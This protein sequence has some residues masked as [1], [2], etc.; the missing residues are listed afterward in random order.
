L[1]DDG[2]LKDVALVATSATGKVPELPPAKRGPIKPK[3]GPF[4]T[5]KVDNGFAGVATLRAL[6]EP[7]VRSGRAG[8]ETVDRDVSA[9]LKELSALVGG[10]ASQPASAELAEALSRGKVDVGI[11]DYANGAGK[12]LPDP[13][14]DAVR[15][16]ALS[17]RGELES[18]LDKATQVAEANK[19]K[20]VWLPGGRKRADARA[21]VLLQHEIEK[22]ALRYVVEPVRR[23]LTTYE[24]ARKALS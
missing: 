17:R 10:S 21:E 4:H 24:R 18:A 8:A 5:E 19:P 12:G 3:P 15:S 9:V 1:L 7:M 6:L 11:R 23:V 20:R 2:G 13:W 16:A 14:R 22:V